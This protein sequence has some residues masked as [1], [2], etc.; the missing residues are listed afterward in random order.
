MRPPHGQKTATTFDHPKV[1]K[2]NMGA[3]HDCRC[4]LRNDRSFKLRPQCSVLE[5]K[6]M[7]PLLEDQHIDSPDVRAKRGICLKSGFDRFNVTVRNNQVLFDWS[8]NE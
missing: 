7:V 6:E 3:F 2:G 4:N 8:V 5:Q 1:T